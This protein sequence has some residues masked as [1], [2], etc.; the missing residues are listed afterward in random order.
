MGQ[1]PEHVRA[2]TGRGTQRVL[3]GPPR[4]TAPRGAAQGGNGTFGT[5]ECLL[6]RYSAQETDCGQGMRAL[7]PT[8]EA[9]CRGCRRCPSR[10]PTRPY[11]PITTHT[12]ITYAMPKHT[13]RRPPSHDAFKHRS[14]RLL[15]SAPYK[16]TPAPMREPCMPGLPTFAHHMLLVSASPATD[17]PSGAVEIRRSG[18]RAIHRGRWAPPNV[19]SQWPPERSA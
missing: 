11:T 10:D 8:T 18:E 2:R 16:H 12:P 13:S 3:R 5:V 7:G 17:G 4:A 14:N 15:A 6:D 1:Q 9:A 19:E